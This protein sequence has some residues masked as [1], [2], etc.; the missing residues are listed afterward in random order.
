MIGFA[1]YYRIANETTE[2]P[3]Q[4]EEHD[5]FRFSIAI[6]KQWGSTAHLA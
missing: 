1:E 3:E 2:K 5:E 6:M 4:T